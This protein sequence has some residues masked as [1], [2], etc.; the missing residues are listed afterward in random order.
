MKAV[1]R[2]IIIRVD[3]QPDKVGKIIIPDEAKKPAYTGIIQ[4]VGDDEDIPS[5]LFATVKVA[6]QKYN[7]TE[8]ERDGE[9]FV[10]CDFEAIL[11]VLD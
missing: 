2:K 7:V 10:S 9:K 6:F 8:F 11:A 1:G 4:S 3:E 5:E